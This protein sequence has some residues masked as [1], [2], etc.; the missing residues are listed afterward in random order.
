MTSK[1]DQ[2]PGRK[3]LLNLTENIDSQID[4]TILKSSLDDL[5]WFI[6][7][8][9]REIKKTPHWIFNDDDLHKRLAWFRRLLLITADTIQIKRAT[10][11]PKFF[12]LQFSERIFLA[13]LGAVLG[14]ALLIHD[15]S[16]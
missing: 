9:N 6:Q 2:T 13:L 16:D 12:D 10:A 8:L 4:D 11:R 3:R 7:T 5:K 15:F 14:W 1:R